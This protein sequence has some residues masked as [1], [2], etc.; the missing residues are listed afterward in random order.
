MRKRKS[1][2]SSKSAV[3]AKQ[4]FALPAECVIGNAGSLR[5]SL[6]TVAKI[7]DVTLDAS[8]VQR[9]DTACLQLLA[10][11]VC[12]RRAA[13]LPVVWAGAPTL[14]AERAQLLGLS[15]T[16]GLAGTVSEALA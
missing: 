6:T 5:E 1:P 3:Q 14:V 12:E 13:K 11:F 4:T 10:A 7:A 9:L 2:Q 15:E 8:A 16:L